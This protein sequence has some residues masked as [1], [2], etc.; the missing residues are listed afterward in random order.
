MKLYNH[1]CF[2][3]LAYGLFALKG[4]TVQ[5][6]C[7]STATIVES[8]IWRRVDSNTITYSINSKINPSFPSDL[9]Q[10]LNITGNQTDGEYHLSISDITESDEGSYRCSISGT[11]KIY[12]EQLTV[13][14]KTFF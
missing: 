6:E 3:A 4:S 1:Y 7:P 8:L 9:Q 10:R 2:L 12:T 11:S 13:I 14:G 5:L